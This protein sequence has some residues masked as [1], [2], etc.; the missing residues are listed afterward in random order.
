M[1]LCLVTAQRVGEVSG[2]RRD[3][4]DLAAR[5]WSLPG[6]RTKNGHPHLV[7]LSPLAVDLI[8]EALADAGAS[9]VRVP[10]GEASLAPTAVAR[11]IVPGPLGDRTVHPARS[12]RHCTFHR[13]RSAG[14]RP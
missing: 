5:T 7:P 6:S 12:V 10:C 8:E 1:K 14:A 11:T 2:M 4:I 3:E 13:A 9:A